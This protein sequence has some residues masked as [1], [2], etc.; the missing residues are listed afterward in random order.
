MESTKKVVFF[1]GIVCSNF[2]PLRE[3]C[4]KKFDI[5]K[6]RV[7]SFFGKTII[8]FLDFQKK[9]TRYLSSE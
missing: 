8:K 4:K 3:A 2:L 7:V 1:Q 5:T 6:K 9:F